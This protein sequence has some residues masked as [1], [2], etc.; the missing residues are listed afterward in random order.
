MIQ[1]NIRDL[2]KINLDLPPLGVQKGLLENF[3]N[4]LAEVERLASIYKQKVAALAE[5]KQT[6]LQKAFTGELTALSAEA[7]QKAAE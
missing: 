5:L 2:K 4:M 1:I 3:G 6:M 7:A